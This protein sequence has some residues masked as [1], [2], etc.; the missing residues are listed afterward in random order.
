[1]NLKRLIKIMYLIS[2]SNLTL[3][4]SINGKELD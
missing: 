1:M 3:N 4:Y 2:L